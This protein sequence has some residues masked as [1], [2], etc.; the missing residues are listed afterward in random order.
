[1]RDLFPEYYKPTEKEFAEL[2]DNCIFVLDTNV[3]LDLYRYSEKSRED[4]FQVLE[5]K[6][7]KERLWL[8]YHV[9][10]EFQKNRVGVL[11][12]QEVNQKNL[13]SEVKRVI[14]EG[15]D[16]LKNSVEETISKH[17]K[18][19]KKEMP[20]NAEKL[21]SLSD[22][23]KQI[24]IREVESHEVK[25]Q[26][27]QEDDLIRERIDTLFSDKVGEAYSERELTQYC[28]DAHERYL[29][30]KPPGY[31]DFNKAKNKNLDEK[32][33]FNQYGDYII[34]KEALEK[35]AA[36]RKP[37]VFVTGDVKEDWLDES[38]GKRIGPRP[39]LLRE[40]I[41][42]TEKRG[43]IYSFES[44]YSFAKEYLEQNVSEE[45]LAEIET[46]EERRRADKRIRMYETA[47]VEAI[48]SLESNIA[49]ANLSATLESIRKSK[50]LGA[51]VEEYRNLYFKLKHYIDEINE[52]QRNRKRYRYINDEIRRE[53]LEEL[54]HEREREHDPQVL[55]RQKLERER[56]ARDFMN[57]FEASPD[58]YI[59][60]YE[61]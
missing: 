47:I 52:E 4:F 19:L 20:L 23:S 35:S 38:K 34:W 13:I 18:S 33:L 53:K 17:K 45:A 40:M 30:E 39:E 42:E 11:T 44:F 8:P 10:Y 49:K 21:L 7:I 41:D 1:M 15:I 51:L 27:H 29:R 59:D 28:R 50:E 46:L 60:P 55:K 48:S 12:S 5:D 6:R 31:K 61:E 58:F 9:A 25:V 57:S 37:L 56:D 43:Y 36:E 14:D 22:K 26:T 32:N 2:W 3:L 16:A 54:R 24:L